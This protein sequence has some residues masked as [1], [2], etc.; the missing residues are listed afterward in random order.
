MDKGWL[1]GRMGQDVYLDDPKFS[2]LGRWILLGLGRT[3][4]ERQ[5]I[6]KVCAH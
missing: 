4:A 2:G 1:E 3:E 6:G 5:G